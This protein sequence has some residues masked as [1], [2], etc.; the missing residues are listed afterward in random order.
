MKGRIITCDLQINLSDTVA[1]TEDF[2][3]III[4]DE[5]NYSKF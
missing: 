1:T 2:E 3:K 5:P 4:M